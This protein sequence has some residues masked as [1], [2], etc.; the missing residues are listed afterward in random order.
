ML[1][2]SGKEK[3]DGWDRFFLVGLSHGFDGAV[4]SLLSLRRVGSKVNYTSFMAHRDESSVESPTWKS[5]ARL[6][7]R[8]GKKGDR[9]VPGTGM[10]DFGEVRHSLRL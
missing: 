6:Y 3:I 4:V 8:K 10:I 7:R 5:R 9:G 2:V 1:F